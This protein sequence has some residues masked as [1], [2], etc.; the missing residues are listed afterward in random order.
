MSLN[1]IEQDFSYETIEQQKIV[2]PLL[3]RIHERIESTLVFAYLNGKDLCQIRDILDRKFNKWLK[4]EE[5][6]YSERLAY[7]YITFFENCDRNGLDE[8]GVR[9]I[10]IGFTKILSCLSKSKQEVGTQILTSAKE[11]KEITPQFVVELEENTPKSIKKN[12]SLDQ[13]P[14][15]GCR[16]CKHYTEANGREKCLFYDE[17]LRDLRKTDN[18]DSSKGCDRIIE[19]NPTKKE[20]VSQVGL[21]Q[22]CWTKVLYHASKHKKEPELFIEETLLSGIEEKTRL[23]LKIQELE[24]QLKVLQ[25]ERNEMILKLRKAEENGLV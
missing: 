6:Q 5:W 23:E 15:T 8:E 9:N 1:I 20:D 24:E 12:Y 7:N 25:F 3:G 19:I 4:S 13:T 21:S 17:F 10:K 18:M 16:N 2:T 22:E 11:G 14:K